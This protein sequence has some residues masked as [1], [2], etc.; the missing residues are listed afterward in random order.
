MSKRILSIALASSLVALS[1]GIEPYRAAAQMRG[2]ARS[3][4]MIEAVPQNGA[5]AGIDILGAPALQ[6]GALNL[7]LDL[8]LSAAPAMDTKAAAELAL[9]HQALDTQS[10]P[11]EVAQAQAE[12]AGEAEKAAAETSKQERRKAS[13]R[14]LRFLKDGAQS[15]ALL[16]SYFDNG[17]PT[18]KTRDALDAVPAAGVDAPVREGSTRSVDFSPRAA[19][20]TPALA[21]NRVAAPEQPEQEPAPEKKKGRIG[22]LLQAFNLS[23]FNRSEK[24]FLAGQ[25]TFLIGLGFYIVSLPLI[26]E[27]VMG[28][29]AETGIFRMVHYWTFIL[30]STVA[31]GVA[32]K[33]PIK[34]TLMTAA[35]LRAAAFMT[36]GVGMMT[37]ALNAWALGAIIFGNAFVVSVNHLVDLDAGGAARVFKGKD[38]EQTDR[39]I[40]KANYFYETVYNGM[41]LMVPW[42]AGLLINLLDHSYGKG[43]GS[44]LGFAVSSLL[45]VTAA[46][47]GYA[48]IR[49]S[50]LSRDVDRE[51]GK[52]GRFRPIRGLLSW[53]SKIGGLPAALKS[54]FARQ[55]EN[56]EAILA[57]KLIA[58]RT[59]LTIFE[60]FVEDAVFFIV[61]PTI[62]VDVLST[63]ASGVGILTSAAFAGALIMA[64]TL[65]GKG[66]GIEKRIGTDK[67]MR[68]LTKLA[69][70]AVIPSVAFWVVPMLGISSYA[71]L[72]MIAMAA[73]LMKGLYVSLKGRLRAMLQNEL[74]TD[75]ATKDRQDEIYSLI[76]IVEVF[77]AGLGGFLFGQSFKWFGQMPTLVGVSVMLGVLSVLYLWSI[78][79]MTA[80]S[81]KPKDDA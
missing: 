41:M 78:R 5:I 40:E 34:K 23:E 76:T 67:F 19:E 6:N 69:A 49:A 9:T 17:V 21:A 18:S 25:T 56:V 77:A 36:L 43:V 26:V 29:T 12:P 37:G 51:S 65:F 8:D 64:G 57:N 52:A 50:D 79:W 81:A 10:S 66:G 2:A 22:R 60:Q 30:G 7:D 53:L 33:T 70:S 68:I 71:G 46:V 35:L 73:F 39:K 11:A 62:A 42:A 45:L 28:S 74:R 80:P 72:A 4:V 75:P 61:L 58:G 31:G 1:A 38:K 3:G 32:A 16:E 59:M 47:L 55:K 48:R 13:E 27:A 15:P 20:V 54:Y 24:A 44:G 63:G 14:T